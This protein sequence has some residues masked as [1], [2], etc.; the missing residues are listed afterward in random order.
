[1]GCVWGCVE[2]VWCVVCEGVWGVCRGVWSVCGVWCVRVCV[3]CVG[4]VWSVECVYGV[5]TGVLNFIEYTCIE[6]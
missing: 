6:F 5:Y 2:C 1:M 3:V 4:C